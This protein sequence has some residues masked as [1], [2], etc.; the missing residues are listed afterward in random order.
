MSFGNQTRWR[1]E[2]AGSAPGGSDS[3]AGVD[4]TEP[5]LFTVQEAARR[6]N[7]PA[8]WLYERTRKDAIPCHRFGKYVRFTVSDLEA[9]IDAAS[10]PGRSML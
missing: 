8:T 3:P 4:G 2:S 5:T 1:P 10:S 6:L 9:I 7:V